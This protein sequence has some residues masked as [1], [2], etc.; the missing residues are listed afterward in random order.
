MPHS[1]PSPHIDA[2]VQI[3]RLARPV[4]REGQQK[5]RTK[6][7]RMNTQHERTHHGFGKNSLCGGQRRQKGCNKGFFIVFKLDK[8]HC[9]ETRMRKSRCANVTKP[10]CCSARI[11]RCT[12]HPYMTSSNK[13]VSVPRKSYLYGHRHFTTAANT[14]LGKALQPSAVFPTSCKNRWCC[15]AFPSSAHSSLPESSG[16]PK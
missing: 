1:E 13:K 12:M 9:Q 3:S 14:L 8:E 4:C 7:S 6:N 2:N 5:H 11:L 10:T 16:E 15:L